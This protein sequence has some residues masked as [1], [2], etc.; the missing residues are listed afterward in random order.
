[1]I[2]TDDRVRHKRE[3]FIPGRTFILHKIRDKKWTHTPVCVNEVKA[4][5]VHLATLDNS[6]GYYC[7]FS[8]LFKKDS[9]QYLTVKPPYSKTFW[10]WWWSLVKYD[11]Q[12]WWMT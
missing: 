4:D 10:E 3:L 9:R 2:T 6:I 1:M 12:H 7:K 5:E 8:T 11:L